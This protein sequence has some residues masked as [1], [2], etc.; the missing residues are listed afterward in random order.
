MPSSGD[1]HVT[2]KRGV[3][4][5]SSYAHV[6]ARESHCKRAAA[7]RVRHAQRRGR[8]QRGHTAR[9]F[10]ALCDPGAPSRAALR[11]RCCAHS[12]RAN[13]SPRPCNTTFKI[14]PARLRPRPRARGECG[15]PCRDPLC[16]PAAL[17]LRSPAVIQHSTNTT[18]LDGV[19]S[20][21]LR[22]E[23]HSDRSWVNNGPGARGPK[24]AEANRAHAHAQRL[25]PEDCFLH[26]RT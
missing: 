4:C 13:R 20:D 7:S 14:M 3:R 23:V 12:K 2:S 6:T 18:K 26:A 5:T 24:S 8:T 17:R 21:L 22:Q 1:P 11:D 16:R 19:A 9:A 15:R 25:W 10:V